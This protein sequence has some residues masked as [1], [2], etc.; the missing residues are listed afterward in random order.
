MLASAH[1]TDV[2]NSAVEMLIAER[3]RIDQAIKL[4]QGKAPATTSA[5]PKAAKKAG[6]R[7][8]RPPLTE[9]ARKAQSEKMKA[10]WAARK[11]KAAKKSS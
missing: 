11:K 10:Y 3:D 8:G 7:R 1:M 5:K 6:K 4:L 9:E 2:T